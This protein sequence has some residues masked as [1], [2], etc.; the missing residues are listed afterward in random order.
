MG[1]LALI[2]QLTM[3]LFSN[4]TS[5]N[6][7]T[8]GGGGGAAQ[9]PPYYGND[10]VHRP[11]G[12]Q[13]GGGHDVVDRSGGS[14]KPDV[15]APLPAPPAPDVKAPLP[16]PPVA[17]SA[18]P[19]PPAAAGPSAAPPAFAAM[20]LSS[21]DKIRLLNFPEHMSTVISE[22]VTRAWPQGIQ[23]QCVGGA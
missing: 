2:S 3:G 8:P 23:Q 13:G 10:P 16:P 22:I 18:P 17:A 20:L 11:G 5:S 12:G 6:N 14:W 9:P 4:K 7:I 1:N 21:T 15:K 19:P